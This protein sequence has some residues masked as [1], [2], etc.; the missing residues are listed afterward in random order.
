MTD[1][2]L[3]FAARLRLLVVLF[4]DAILERD[5]LER[6]ELRSELAIFAA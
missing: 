2:Q 6:R 3:R 4:W 5:T 1:G